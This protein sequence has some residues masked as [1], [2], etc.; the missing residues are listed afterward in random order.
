MP[1]TES[2]LMEK[3]ISGIYLVT[4]RCSDLL[5]RVEIA[6]QC[7]VGIVQYREKDPH[8]KDRLVTACR[9]RIR[10]RK[11]RALFIVND[12]PLLALKCEADGVH[13]GQGDLSPAKAREILGKDALIGVSTHCLAEAV[14]A[15]RA[16]ADYIGFGCLFPT[17]TKGDT[18]PASLEELE[19]VR[20][21]VSIP[22]VAIGGIDVSNLAST[23]RSGADA[24]AVISAIARS[25]DCRAAV[26]EL[27]RQYRLGKGC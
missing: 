4:E 13:L 8:A 1:E 26:S 3:T 18:T 20:K 17:R 10:C 22:I 6:L 5:E 24:A 7:G 23:I 9:L 2:R 21:A 25:N 27:L 19:R 14:A 16:G 12:D 15:E 11:Y